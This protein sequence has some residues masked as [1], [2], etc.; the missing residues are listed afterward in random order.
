MPRSEKT[1]WE[2]DRIWYCTACFEELSEH[3]D[4]DSYGNELLGITASML[5]AFDD[6][7]SSEDFDGPDGP[8]FQ[9]LMADLD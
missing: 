1:L 3:G 6:E 2:L 4:S 7:P 9:A 8:N 5:G